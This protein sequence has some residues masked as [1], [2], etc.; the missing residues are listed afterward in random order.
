[1]TASL[2]WSNH[3]NCLN[4]AQPFLSQ[5]RTLSI[6]SGNGVNELTM[7]VIL[8]SPL[9]H[10]IFE[11][12]WLDTKHTV[13]MPDCDTR[14]VKCLND[15]LTQGLILN[16]VEDEHKSCDMLIRS[17]AEAG[18]LLGINIA[19][20]SLAFH[21]MHQDK[22]DKENL[23]INRNESGRLSEDSS[24]LQLIKSNNTEGNQHFDSS[25][26]ADK[27]QYISIR[28]F[29]IWPSSIENLVESSNICKDNNEISSEIINSLLSPSKHK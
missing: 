23:S 6:S 3:F 27:S 14:T 18:K 17:V 29:A 5:S 28:S 15:L 9:L 26:Y 21:N 20:D 7:N 12:I 2:S 25:D 19:E 10:N 8:F 22:S 16:L 13:I 11:D 4:K 1:M 24:Q